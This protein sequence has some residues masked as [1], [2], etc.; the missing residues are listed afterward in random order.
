MR[1]FIAIDIP[2]SLKDDVEANVVE[3]LRGRLAGARVTWVRAE[4]RHITLK[5]LGNVADGQI[6]AVSRA[7]ENV[8]RRHAKFDTSFEELGGFPHL[9]RPRVLWL[10]LGE[11]ALNATAIAE[12]LDV[13]LE[14]L[15]FPREG[16]PFHAHLTLV[17]FRSPS[18]REMPFEYEIPGDAFAVNEVV[19]F[20]SQLHPKGAR[21]TA[22]RRYPLSA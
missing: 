7:V 18:V 19:L 6:D 14:P 2:Q 1:L 10:G 21:Y 3:P 17:R 12:D 4:G 8:S 22:L 11:G 20:Q 9:R 5:F 16:R 15:G 13:H